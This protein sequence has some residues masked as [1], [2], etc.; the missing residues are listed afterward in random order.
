MVSVAA[1]IVTVSLVLTAVP[2]MV[3]VVVVHS[4]FT[5]L[6]FSAASVEFLLV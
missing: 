3:S 5:T 2:L 1:S 6:Q 4:S